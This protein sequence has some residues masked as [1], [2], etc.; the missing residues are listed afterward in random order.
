MFHIWCKQGI[1]ALVIWHQGS[2]VRLG[3]DVA[4]VDHSI[5]HRKLDRS[6]TSSRAVV[7]R[8]DTIDEHEPVGLHRE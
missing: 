1:R 4:T 7:G 8:A 3:V 2:S 5:R 6:R